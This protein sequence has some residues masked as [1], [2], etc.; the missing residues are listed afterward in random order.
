MENFKNKRLLAVVAHPDDETFGM[1]GT[2]AYY[3]RQG[4][5][6]YLI[7][8]TRGEAGEVDAARLEG[9]GSI[10]ELREH[11]LH[12]AADVLGIKKVHFLD[13]R[14]SGMPGSSDNQYP[15]ALIQAPLDTVANAIVHQIR[16]IK[17]QV[18]LTFDPIGGYMHPDHIAIH[19][20]TVAAFS[21]ASDPRLK[22]QTLA[23]YKPQKLYF[24]IIPHRFLKLVVRFMPLFG[25]DPRKF[26]KNGDIDLTAILATDFPIHAWINYKSVAQVRDDASACH[27]SQGGD[28]KSGYIVTWL[29]R[30][31][32]SFE[33]YM[34]AYPLPEEGYIEK[35]LFEGVT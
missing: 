33:T 28:R 11:E 16:S 29:L 27:A 14:D 26:G 10:A 6:V 23:P 17:P 13:Y 24:H 4:V 34:R 21:A 32:S 35:D 8:A 7:C 19:K 31:I 20:A 5:D 9:Y 15:K 2:L 12:C 25:K 1:G 22:A 30:Q 18:V 3:A